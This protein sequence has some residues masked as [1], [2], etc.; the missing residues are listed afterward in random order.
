MAGLGICVYF[1]AVAVSLRISRPVARAMMTYWEYRQLED[2]SQ[3]AG[4]LVQLEV[5]LRTWNSQYVVTTST[6]D[7]PSQQ[8]IFSVPG[9]GP[10]APQALLIVSF[11]DTGEFAWL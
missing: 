10:N 2:C 4:D 8:L 5:V 3:I 6:S 7:E 11:A 9:A 1:V